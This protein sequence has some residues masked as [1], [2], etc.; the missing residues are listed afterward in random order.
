MNYCEIKNRI[1]QEK[2]SH[3]HQRTDYIQYGDF[4]VLI[5]TGVYGLIDSKIADIIATRKWCMD[6][7]GYLIAN[8]RGKIVRLHDVVM[9]L[10]YNEKPQNCYVDHI[11]FDKLDNRLQNLRFVTP[12]ESAHNMPLKANNTSGVTGVTRTKQGS[13]RAYITTNKKRIELGT[14]QTLEEATLARNEAETRLGFKT[15]PSNIASLLS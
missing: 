11:N 13:F 8:M 12:T 5:V 2:Q 14:Y 6:S 1:Y 4:C 9:A 7:H 15:R 3:E 10:S